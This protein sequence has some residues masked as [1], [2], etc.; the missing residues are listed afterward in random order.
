[1]FRIFLQKS[2]F[3]DN[4]QR[5][6]ATISSG[7]TGFGRPRKLRLP[8][9]WTGATHSAIGGFRLGTTPPKGNRHSCYREDRRVVQLMTFLNTATSEGASSLRSVQ[10]RESSTY[11]VDP[12]GFWKSHEVRAARPLAK[13]RER[14][15]IHSGNGVRKK[16]GREAGPLPKRPSQRSK[17]FPGCFVEFRTGRSTI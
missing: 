1:V 6:P 9:G 15:G 17:T 2:G 16:H 11:A 5:L 14:S 12:G 3:C 8:S 7:C 10:G 13:T 4:N